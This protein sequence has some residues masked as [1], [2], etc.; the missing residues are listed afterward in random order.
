MQKFRSILGYAWA[1]A[2]LIVALATFFGNDAF[3]R[4]IAGTGIKINP[5]FSGGEVD[6][7]MVRSGY[8]VAVH[9]PVFEALVGRSRSGFVQLDFKPDSV[10]A[11]FILA[12]D[13]SPSSP[14]AAIPVEFAK[15]LGR[16]IVDT[17]IMRGGAATQVTIDQAKAMM[18]LDP[19]D[20]AAATAPLAI[21]RVD[22][23][24]DSSLMR[25]Y[26]QAASLPKGARI[27]YRSV[28]W[29]PDSCLP[30]SVVDTVG[31][32]GGEPLCTVRLDTRT[33]TSTVTALAPCVLGTDRAYKLNHG[34]AV[35]V[36]LRNCR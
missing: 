18:V 11:W 2:A 15:L 7:V 31:C 16:T 17:I 30:E 36:K 14:S 3:S 1:A 35:R 9:R 22:W 24:P 21:S 20:P 6:T 5:K 13:G 23:K 25:T 33:G 26:I 8:L 34:W 28:Y 12:N 32:S 4:A 27:P 29:A 19:L 10:A